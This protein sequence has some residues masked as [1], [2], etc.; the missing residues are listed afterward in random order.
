MR[1]KTS[2]FRSDVEQTAWSIAARHLARGQ[3][4]PVKMI[5]EAIEQ[6]RNRCVELLRAAGGPKVDVPVFLIDPDHEW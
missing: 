2:V 3:K 4:D 5:C 1:E 6:E